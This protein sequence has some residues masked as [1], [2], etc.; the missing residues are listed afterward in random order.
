[1]IKFLLVRKRLEDNKQFDDL[2][3]AKLEQMGL[4]EGEQSSIAVVHYRDWKNPENRKKPHI[5]L[6][7]DTDG[8]DLSVIV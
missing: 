1:V 4:P 7:S 5:S 2:E 6:G 8:V 3:G